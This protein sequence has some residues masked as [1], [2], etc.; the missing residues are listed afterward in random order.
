MLPHIVKKGA[1]S[2]QAAQERKN[3]Q[4]EKKQE[5]EKRLQDVAGALGNATAA[6]KSKVKKGLE[7][8]T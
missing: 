2:S 8:I 3:E 7:N 5:L 1:A 6:A 4:L